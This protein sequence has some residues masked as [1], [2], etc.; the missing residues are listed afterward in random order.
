M[1]LMRSFLSYFL[2]LLL[3]SQV[4]AARPWTDQELKDFEK[5][6]HP[7]FLS[8]PKVLGKPL[9]RFNYLYEI[10][11]TADFIAQYQV[12]DSSSPDFGGLIEAEH[13]P[14]IIETDNTQ[15]AIWVWSRW[16]E[17]TGRD[18][19]RIN[20]R[21]AWIYV[22][23]YPAY[24]EGP[25]YYC[26]WNC[27]LGFFAERK[28]RQVYGDSSFIPYTDTCLQ[29]MYNHPL[30]LTSSLNAFVNGFAAGMLYAYASE[31][32][33][34]VAKDTALF[35]GNRTRLW[36]EAGARNRLSSGEWAMSGG[37]A[38]WGICSSIYLED[39]LAGKNWIRIYQD[40]LPFFY[41]VGQWNNSWN[42]WLANG[43]R[44]GAMISHNDTFGQFIMF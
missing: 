37:T 33:N 4:F 40:S 38:M 31:K 28:Y 20:I 17:L 30:P 16:F 25:D 36:I 3:V 10:K 12:S 26:V 44:A 42:I 14:N 29:Y 9:D 43:Y 39:T 1:K 15:E 13:L 41:P 22:M 6:F 19:Y 34:H 32:N 5:N 2:L 11:Q 8:R 21:R 23:H 24:R 7:Q 35:Y 18:D 27:G